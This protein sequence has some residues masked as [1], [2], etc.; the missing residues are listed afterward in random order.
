MTELAIIFWVVVFLFLKIKMADVATL[1]RKWHQLNQ[2]TNNTEINH[3]VALASD[4]LKK[5][6]QLD[7]K[8]VLL[9]S[10]AVLP[11]H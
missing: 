5:L 8:Q 6:K 9:E 1:L 11:E 4:I 7:D 2:A 10:C 3:D